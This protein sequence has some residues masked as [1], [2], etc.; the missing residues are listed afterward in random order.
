MKRGCAVLN[1]VARTL[2]IQYM[3]SRVKSNEEP[4][5]TQDKV[6]YTLWSRDSDILGQSKSL[7]TAP[8]TPLHVKLRR[9]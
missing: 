7:A 4:E 1:P 6:V 5:L 3:R 8:R 9:T 2:G